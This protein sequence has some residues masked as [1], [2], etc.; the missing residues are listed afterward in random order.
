MAIGILG[1]IFGYGAVGVFSACCDNIRGFFTKHTRI[2]RF[3]VNLTSLYP[4]PVHCFEAGNS[5][6]A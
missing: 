5:L 4:C 1:R 2:A 3:I 6:L